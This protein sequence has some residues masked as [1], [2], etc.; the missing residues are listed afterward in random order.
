LH[1]VEEGDTMENLS[2]RYYGTPSRADDIR[3]ANPNLMGL[4]N[5]G[6]WPGLLLEIPS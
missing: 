6:L 1:T 5:W 3:N 4:D 2:Q